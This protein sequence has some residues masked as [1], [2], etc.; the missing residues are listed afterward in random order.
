[1]LA[2]RLI[3]FPEVANG[4]TPPRIFEFTV[5]QRKIDAENNLIRVTQGD[6]A[7]SRFAARSPC[8]C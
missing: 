8:W 4:Q 2:L 3:A 7:T 6:A 1:V 5:K